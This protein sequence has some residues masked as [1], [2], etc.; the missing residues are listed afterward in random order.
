MFTWC[1]LVYL[2][3]SEHSSLLLLLFESGLFHCTLFESIALRY[4]MVCKPSLGL[5]SGFHLNY[6]K[7]KSHQEQTWTSDQ[8]VHIKFKE[9]LCRRHWNLWNIQC[10][11]QSVSI[12]ESLTRNRVVFW[13]P[14]ISSPGCNGCHYWARGV[15]L[16]WLACGG[17]G[18]RHAAPEALQSEL[19]GCEIITKYGKY[20]HAGQESFTL[21][22]VKNLIT[23]QMSFKS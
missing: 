6:K 8:H 9:K 15:A 5:I 17:R 3:A 21:K 23:K 22:Y 19:D 4:Q 13:W 1:L 14:M 16:F 7:K 18:R 20:G 12:G 11:F 10:F 2:K